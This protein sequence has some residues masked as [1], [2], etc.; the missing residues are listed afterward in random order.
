V[1]DIHGHLW[2]TPGY[3]DELVAASKAA[4]IEKIC[5]N[6]LGDGYKQKT[7][8]DV[9]AAAKAYPDVVIPIG[10]LR[11]G[12]DPPGTVTEM[13]R[14]GF[15]GL[16]VINPVCAYDDEAYFD[17]YDEAAGLGLPILF[18]TGIIARRPLDRKEHVNCAKMKP[19]TLDTIARAIPTLNLIMA[20]LGV[21]WYDEAFMV[22]RTNPNVYFEITS[23]AGWRVKGMGPQYFKQKLW[24]PGAWEK[25]VFGTD[26]KTDRIQWSV[27][28]YR[29]I[30]D[31]AGVPPETQRKIYTDTLRRLLPS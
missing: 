19:V 12:V 20:H 8:D 21:P 4:G 2:D 7:N 6:G 5:L 1:I 3:L 22:T 18:H 9:L 15:K 14:R 17:H 10:Y 11:L 29:V 13:A 23:G 25:M 30:L 28:E 26:V 16:K 27:D 31:G 24:W